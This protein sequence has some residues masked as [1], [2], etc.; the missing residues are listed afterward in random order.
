[1]N[2]LLDIIRNCSYCNKSGH[3]IY[4]C[5]DSSLLIFGNRIEAQLRDGI[6]IEDE[7][8]QNEYSI[9]Q[10]TLNRWLYLYSIDNSDIIFAY[11]VSKCNAS[12]LNNLQECINMIIKHYIPEPEEE[13]ISFVDDADSV[14]L[15]SNVDNDFSNTLLFLRQHTEEHTEQIKVVNIN[16]D[17]ESESESESDSDS[18]KYYDSTCVIC[19][20]EKHRYQMVKLNCTHWYCDKCTLS[21]LESNQSNNKE[22]SCPL[23]RCKIKTILINNNELQI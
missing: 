17:S 19:G 14:Y 16:I 10:N 9:I 22:H 12:L 15:Q 1:M 2:R 18:N 23:C 8:T 13:F 6:I 21:L 5:N 7:D 3:R 4:N 20:E 11:A